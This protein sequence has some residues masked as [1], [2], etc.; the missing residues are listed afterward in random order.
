[1]ES[2]DMAEVVPLFGENKSLEQPVIQT[3]WRPAEQPDPGLHRRVLEH[4]FLREDQN[5]AGAA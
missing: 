1:M 5:Q 4:L 2:Q 3:I